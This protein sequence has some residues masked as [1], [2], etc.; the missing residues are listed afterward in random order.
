MWKGDLKH[1]NVAE[2]EKVKG[3]VAGF[4]GGGQLSWIFLLVTI[5]C[6]VCTVRAFLE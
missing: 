1:L 5:L 2:Q 4:M 6:A 3:L